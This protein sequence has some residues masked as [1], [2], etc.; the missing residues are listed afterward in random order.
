MNGLK[1]TIKGIAVLL[2]ACLLLC[3]PAWGRASGEWE[4]AL[5]ARTVQLWIDAQLLDDIVLNARAELNVTW[6]PRT[7]RKR[8]ERD[9]DVHEW[10]VK[11]LGCYYPADKEA[12]RRMKGRDILALNYRA[13]KNWDFDPTRLTVGGYRVTPE[14][15]LGHRDLRVTGELPPG[16]EGTLFLCVPALKPGSRVE[17]TMGPDRAVLEA[18]AR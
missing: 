17:I 2:L 5:E 10:V 12:E 3:A 7:L 4:K 18:P 6:L 14:D 16:T 1:K 13:V 8:L 11:G 9:R 15:L